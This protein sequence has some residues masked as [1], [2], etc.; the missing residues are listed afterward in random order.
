MPNRNYI[1]GRQLEYD[2]KHLLEQA[3]YTITRAS[4]SRSPFDIIAVRSFPTCIKEIWLIQCK[5]KQHDQRRPDRPR[6]QRRGSSKPSDHASVPDAPN[7]PTSRGSGI[8]TLTGPEN[9]GT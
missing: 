3:G 7:L 8:T 6:R 4:G 9:T 1:R 5:V 2:V